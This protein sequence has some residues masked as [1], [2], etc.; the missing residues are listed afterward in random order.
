MEV[1][2]DSS[3]YKEMQTQDLIIDPVIKDEIIIGK[4]GKDIKNDIS[5]LTNE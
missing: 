2:L 1:F 5:F 4:Y 3:I